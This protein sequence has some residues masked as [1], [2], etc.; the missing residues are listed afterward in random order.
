MGE[1]E[2]ERVGRGRGRRRHP[3]DGTDKDTSLTRRG[4]TEVPVE[5]GVEGSSQ[6]R[7]LPVEDG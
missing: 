1:E 7:S 3:G 5:W 2:W 4:S 6:R